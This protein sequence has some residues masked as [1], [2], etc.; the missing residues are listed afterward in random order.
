M[1]LFGGW[2][3]QVPP[4]MSLPRAYRGASRANARACLG[5]GYPCEARV[6]AALPFG[7]SF[8]GLHPFA[9]GGA[10]RAPA[11]PLYSTRCIE[12]IACAHSVQHLKADAYERACCVALYQ[13]GKDR[14]LRR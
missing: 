11:K 3:E 8:Y 13:Q 12:A 6:L 2:N 4:G 9:A 10:G 1:R 14:A 7:V 5:T